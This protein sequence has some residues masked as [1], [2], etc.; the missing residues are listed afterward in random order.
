MPDEDLRVGVHLD[1]ADFLRGVEAM[2]RGT[3]SF[4][5]EL[6]SAMNRSRRAVN[7]VNQI[8]NRLDVAQIAVHQSQE[9][10]RASQE[11][12]GEAVAKYGEKSK[13]AEKA[14]RDME[15]AQDALHQAQQRS[16]LSVGLIVAQTAQ[17]AARVPAAV[18]GLRALTIAQWNATAAAGALSS[19]MTL[20]A[21]AVG[22]VAS[23]MA[24][25]AAVDNASNSYEAG[26]ESAAEW[27]TAQMLAALRAREAQLAA[28][29]LSHTDFDLFNWDT[30]GSSSRG[31]DTVLHDIHNVRADIMQN[32]FAIAESARNTAEE[33][34]RSEQVKALVTARDEA[35]V[36][37]ELTKTAEVMRAARDAM[38][39]PFTEEKDLPNL[40]KQFEDSVTYAS[41]L[42]GVL[43]EIAEARVRSTEEANKAIAA[44]AQALRDSLAQ[45]LDSF[46]VNLQELSVVTL[47]S[48]SSFSGP[49][50][51][52][53]ATLAKTKAAETEMAAAA[54]RSSKALRDQAEITAD[55]DE[56]TE[57]FHKRLLDLGFAEEE[58]AK[59]VDETGRALLR[60]TEATNKAASAA[61]RASGNWR[62]G[63]MEG[64]GNSFGG[65]HDIGGHGAPGSKFGL[66]AFLEVN[67]ENLI[68]KLYGFPLGSFEY[69]VN[70]GKLFNSAGIMNLLRGQGERDSTDN[71][72]GARTFN[73]PG[74]KDLV[75]QLI[76]TTAP[77]TQWDSMLKE[78]G[79]PHFANGFDGV[80][81]RASLF[82]AGEAGPERVTV[83]PT[84]R[85]GSA[86][87][88]HINVYAQD[89]RDAG[90]QIARRLK[91]LGVFGSG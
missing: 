17:L 53:A 45:G 14:A 22:I 61:D 67:R 65:G 56:T 89:G 2:K 72:V 47:Q 29:E 64:T 78:L 8:L 83:S 16:V 85:G 31:L 10:L 58:I 1:L 33:V 37:A 21:A 26:A 42:Q 18:A 71:I 36:R 32:E 52:I 54:L 51:E 73:M 38:L 70:N 86:P 25:K 48:L 20:G 49:L 55:K 76:L 24:I 59:R 75:K 19:A 57:Q 66:Q 35:V 44:Q 60:Q 63:V 30:W 3:R 77:A 79:V 7:D 23:I 41:R 87:V 68:S 5:D 43:D 46:G 9:N 40:Q 39:D 80:V 62:S 69:N 84:G 50:G 12:Y 34:I 74:F 90:E 27:G 81:N 6:V 91:G 15:K 88:I 13:E 4:G 82:V 28:E 11:R